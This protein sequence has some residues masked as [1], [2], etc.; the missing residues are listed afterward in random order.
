MKKD[1]ILNVQTKANK[2]IANVHYTLKTQT[3]N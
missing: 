2:A 3:L 1:E